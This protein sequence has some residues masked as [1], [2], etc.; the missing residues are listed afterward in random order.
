MKYARVV[1]TTVQ[2]VFTAPQGFSVDE[3]FTPELVA[4]FELCPDEV[5]GGWLKLEDGT[6][7]APPLPNTTI[8]GTEQ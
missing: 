8:D 2:E 7:T 1:D 6:F 4:Q 5:Q 3:C